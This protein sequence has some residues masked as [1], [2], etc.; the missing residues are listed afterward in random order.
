VGKDHA[1]HAVSITRKIESIKRPLD[2][3]L[4]GENKEIICLLF[5]AW[6]A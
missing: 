3:D 5:W 6:D 4:D 1:V 2:I